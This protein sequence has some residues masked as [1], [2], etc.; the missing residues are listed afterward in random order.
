LSPTRLIQYTRRFA[1]APLARAGALARSR[2]VR[3]LPGYAKLSGY[4]RAIERYQ[5][6][7]A[8]PAIFS[9]TRA[10]RLRQGYPSLPVPAILRV[11][12]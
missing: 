4:A 11:F 7:S 12:R 5:R 10:I 8:I 2:A 1:G 9:D 3:R 6:Y